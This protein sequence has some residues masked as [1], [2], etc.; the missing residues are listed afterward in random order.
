MYQLSKTG[1]FNFTKFLAQ[2]AKDSELIAPVKTDTTRYQVIKDSRSIYLDGQSYYP[3]KE[4]FFRVHQ[5]IFAFQDGKTKINSP[6]PRPRVFLGLRRCDL[7]AIHHQDIGLC[8]EIYYEHLREKTLFIGIHCWSTCNEYAFCGSLSL[9][10]CYDLMLYEY[11]TYYLVETG[12][13]E[14]DLFVA[15]YKQFF[16]KTNETI[17]PEKKVIANADRLKVL[18]L[19]PLFDNPHWQEGVNQ[20]FSCA[21]CVMLCP[22]CY[23]FEIKDSVNSDNLSSGERYRSWSS[24]QLRSF[25]RVA[26]NYVF[27]DKRDE[28]FKH[29]IYHQLSYFKEKH[30]INLCVGCGRCISGCPSRIDFVKLLNEMKQ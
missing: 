14:G 19:E 7:N 1:A 12:T 4:F 21:A 3:V 25:S 23:C 6:K 15:K 8:G 22:T 24:C 17:T 20:C 9:K 13:P 18:E 29:R 30:G 11:K 16:K 26:G 28:R 10:D 5:Q 27:R 2:L